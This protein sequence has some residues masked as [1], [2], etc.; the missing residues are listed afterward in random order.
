MTH[1]PLILQPGGRHVTKSPEK[2]ARADEVGQGWILLPIER[3]DILLEQ[4]PSHVDKAVTIVLGQC[5]GHVVK[6]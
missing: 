5:L 6:D 3:P 2:V 1:E 4:C